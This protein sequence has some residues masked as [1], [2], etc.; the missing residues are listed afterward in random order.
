MMTLNMMT[1]NVNAKVKVKL[2]K[3]G[4]DICNRDTAKWE[5]TLHRRT[6]CAT[7]GPTPKVEGDYWEGP[8]WD[9][10][11][12]W[13]QFLNGCEIPFVDNVLHIDAGA[14][15]EART[16][17]TDYKETQKPVQPVQRFHA[18]D[19]VEVLDKPNQDSWVHAWKH[20]RS[21][22]PLPTM[23]KKDLTIFWLVTAFLGALFGNVLAHLALYA[24]Y[25]ANH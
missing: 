17:R 19:P 10:M 16:L 23:N 8:L 22:H 7:D 24:H 5:C 18:G 2:T 3:R 21:S 14:E 1:L 13:G 11:N 12:I 4:A 9:L 20:P 25:A 15:A 6:G